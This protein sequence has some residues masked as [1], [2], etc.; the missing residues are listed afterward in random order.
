MGQVK[1]NAGGLRAGGA[2]AGWGA[3]AVGLLAGGLLLLVVLTYLVLMQTG[4]VG[5]LVMH[6]PPAVERTTDRTPVL[7]RDPAP[8]PSPAAPR[9]GS[10]S[11]PSGSAAPGGR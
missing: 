3:V 4:I 9:S 6:Q 11:G 7:E 10:P 2:A 8:A 5:P 1:V